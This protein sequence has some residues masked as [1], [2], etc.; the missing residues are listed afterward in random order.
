[1]NKITKISVFTAI[2]LVIIAGGFFANNALSKSNRIS[3]ASTE[4]IQGTISKKINLIGQVKA[5]QGVDMSFE[6]SGKIT[7]NYVKVGDK[8]T[9]GQ[10]LVSIDSSI[11]QAQLNQARAQLN[12]AK[13]QTNTIS[14]E[15]TQNKADSS[16]QT[17]RTAALAYAQKSVT[18]A[19]N[20]LMI[21]TD[22]QYNH[23][24]AKWAGQDIAIEQAKAKAAKSLLGAEG[25]GGWTSQSLSILDDGAYGQVQ[26]AINNPTAE[27]IDAAINAAFESLKDIRSL[28]DAIP[29]DTSITATERSSIVAEKSYISGEIITLSNAIQAISAQQVNNDATITTTSA[30]IE[31][32]N[33][34]VKTIEANIQAIQTQISKTTL[35]AL[36]NGQI[37]KNDAIVGALA[38]AGSPVITISN[39]N[40]EIQVSI[41]ESQIVNIKVGN[42]ADVTL[43][44][45]GN[46]QIFRASVVSIDTA[47]T[48]ENG[49]AVY[50]A[51]LKFETEN[52]QIKSGM[53]A[54]V[55]ITSATQENVVMVP[56]TAI[57]QKAGRY[58]VIIDKGVEEKE[59]RE[60]S[61]GIKDDKNTEII[62]GL[63]AGEKVISY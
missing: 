39:N 19:K 50:K 27:N 49:I 55:T 36:F 47:T 7:A 18:V 54:N 48:M 41:P 3:L 11:L 8:I 26:I 56:N 46:N 62:S 40:L 14:L 53:T 17:A 13:A 20:S 6:G 38:V 45:F 4:V 16:L 10:A 35:R 2:I 32:A 9:A 29:L 51:R 12:Q 22:I 44:A 31:A 15:T 24:M 21:M 33:A 30:Q 5:S 58:F 43:D 28:I 23:F 61:I 34:N 42:I 52:E 59:N 1:M 60:V 63:Q 25:A 37:D 57:I